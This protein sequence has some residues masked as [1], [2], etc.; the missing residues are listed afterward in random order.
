MTLAS[1]KVAAYLYRDEV[2]ADAP[3]CPLRRITRNLEITIEWTKDH[4]LLGLHYLT[5]TQFAL[6]RRA[7]RDYAEGVVEVNQLS[8]WTRFKGK[9]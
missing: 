5:E 6:I 1:G 3:L 7:L 8:Y 2:Y 9:T 4:C